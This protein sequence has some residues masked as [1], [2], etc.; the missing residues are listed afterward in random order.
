MK[1]Q[2]PNSVDRLPPHAPDAE[3]GILGCLLLGGTDVHDECVRLMPQGRDTFYDLRHQ[4][5]FTTLVR[6]QEERGVTA[7]LITLSERLR[8]SGQ[9][10]AVGGLTYLNQIADSV[11]SAAN[12]EYYVE[13]AVAKWKLRQIVTTCTRAVTEAYGCEGTPDELVDRVEAAIHGVRDRCESKQEGPASGGVL[14]QLA[15]DRMERRL[16]GMS[17]IP[18]GFKNL[19]KVTDGFR[20]GEVS[21]IAAAPS[22][23]KTA[24]LL[25]IA[26]NLSLD[27]RIPVG[28]LTLEQS[29]E[30]L[31]ERIVASRAKVNVRAT[32][33]WTDVDYARVKTVTAEVRER[34]HLHIDDAHGFD[35]IQI[36]AAARRLVRRQ[37]VKAVFVDYLQKIEGVSRRAENATHERVAEASR[38][39]QV[40][41]KELDVPI[42]A[43][44]QLTRDF[45]A[46]NGRPELKDLAESFGI[47]KDADFVG[48]MYRKT[49]DPV[50]MAHE[51]RRGFHPVTMWV[52]KQ[53][54]GER[55]RPVQLMFHPRFTRFEDA[56]PID[57]AD[58]PSQ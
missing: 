28:F 39:L 21:I 19:D 56:S 27:H 14:A 49:R 36:R 8:S 10:E 52:A 50:V 41:S 5:I 42:I 45:D 43:G 57:A 33:A 58:I 26:S 55:N 11:P 47:A 34:P 16:E 22:G 35:I 38:G 17:G 51:D 30:Q 53:R 15:I 24:I 1:T 48:I 12:L 13:D 32:S 7:D 40:L 2:V 44:A 20:S 46:G 31:A 3:R 18:S 23:G 37:G 6:M 4:E 29:K 54:D 25:N 9:L